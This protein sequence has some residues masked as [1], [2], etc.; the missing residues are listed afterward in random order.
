MKDGGRI[1]T[2]QGVA[3]AEALAGGGI[4]AT[5][6]MSSPTDE[7]LAKL[8]AHVAEGSIKVEVQRTFPLAEANEALAA[9]AAGT[10]GKLVLVVG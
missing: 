8:A 10:R 9:F 7:K 2:T 6:I 5:N 4:K 3:D 1:A